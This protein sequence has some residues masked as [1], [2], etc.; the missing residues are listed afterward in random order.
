MYIRTVSAPYFSMS[1]S[2]ET[3]LPL[4]FDIFAPSLITMPW[5]NRLWNGS[6]KSTIL[7]SRSTFVKKR[8]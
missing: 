6:W 5:V 3:T 4:D 8:E 1:S 7:R 2:G